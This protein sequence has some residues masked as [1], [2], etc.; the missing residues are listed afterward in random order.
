MG[1]PLGGLFAVETLDTRFGSQTGGK[2]LPTAQPSK[3]KT[4]EYYMYYLAFLTI[5][6]LM[7]KAVYDVSGPWH[8]SY[9]KYEHLL[10]PGWIPGRKVDNSDAQ[11]RGFRENIPYMALL[12]VLHPL[13][14]KGY[15]RLSVCTL[16]TK[17]IVRLLL[18]PFPRPLYRARPRSKI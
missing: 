11:Y 5:P 17:D 10:E 15:E 13:L 12:I 7:V 2:S 4:P 16:A 8:P 6:V 14:R 9:A 18:I 1:N 3:W